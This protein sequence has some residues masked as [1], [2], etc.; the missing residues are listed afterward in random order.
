MP[1]VRVRRPPQRRHRRCRPSPPRRRLRRRMRPV[2]RS[3][4]RETDKLSG[5]FE[6]LDFVAAVYDQHGDMEPA[7]SRRDGRNRSGSRRGLRDADR[8]SLELNRSA[9][10]RVSRTS[11]PLGPSKRVA[12]SLK[13][14]TWAP[15]SFGRPCGRPSPETEPFDTAFVAALEAELAIAY[16][17]A[18][19]PAGRFGRGSGRRPGGVGSGLAGLAESARTRPLPR[20]VQPDP[21]QRLPHPA[22]PAEQAGAR[23]T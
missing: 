16:R 13:K 14:P 3:T 6:R 17:L 20:V 2:D 21:R 1:D 11:D 4:V 19:L 5:S 8:D 18:G 10:S 12:C 23:S 7:R 22:S 15:I 9:G